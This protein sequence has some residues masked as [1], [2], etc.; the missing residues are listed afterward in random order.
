MIKHDYIN[1]GEVTSLK[2]GRD[3]TT[4]DTQVLEVALHVAK[5]TSQKPIHYYYVVSK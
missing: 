3:L 1:I 4:R 5:G 2:T